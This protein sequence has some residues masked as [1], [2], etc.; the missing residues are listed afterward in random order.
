MQDDAIPSTSKGHGHLTIA[1]LINKQRE[2][3]ISK[4]TESAATES[5]AAE[6]A[7]S[8]SAN[9]DFQEDADP[10]AEDEILTPPIVWTYDQSFENVAAFTKFLEE[11]NCWGLIN[12]KKLDRGI[13][14]V[15][16]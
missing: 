3:D 2:N 4:T 8:E 14:S 5:A 11:E 6:S 16:R 12:H 9:D 10:E 7:A 13:K 1:D 15:Y